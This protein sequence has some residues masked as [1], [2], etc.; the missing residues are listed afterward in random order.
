[1]TERNPILS[2]FGDEAERRTENPLRP[3]SIAE[4]VGQSELIEKMQIFIEAAKQ[5][6]EPLDHVLLFGPPGLGKTTMARIIAE[7]LGVGFKQHQASAI[8]RKDSLAAIL[9]DVAEGDVLFIDEVHRLTGAVEECLY[10]AMEDYEFHIVIGDGPHGRSIKL[11][12][13]HFTLVGATTRLG[14]LTAPLRARFPIT[15]RLRFYNQDELNE[16]VHRTARIQNAPID[17]EGARE[18]ARR[19]RGTPRIANRMV[20][21]V[22]DY[23]QVRADGKI[24][25]ETALEAFDKYEIDDLGLE[26]VDRLFLETIIE[27]FDGGPV[28]LNS[29]AVAISEDEDTIEDYVEPY[30][31]QIGFMKRTPRGRVLTARAFEHLGAKAPKEIGQGEL[32]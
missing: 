23:V 26:N 1:M 22:R 3:K 11:D 29:I 31:I 21:R 14:M 30:L 5:R 24:T 32:F 13:K 28:G 16:I 2:P 4:F 15:E 8:D 10:P 19:A 9:T 6:G 18:L 7:E 12:L 25:R 27:K 17:E 20:N